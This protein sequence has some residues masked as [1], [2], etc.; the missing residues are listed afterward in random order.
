MSE[1]SDK[2]M[3]VRGNVV[4]VETEEF[5]TVRVPKAKGYEML[6]KGEASEVETE[7]SETEEKEK[8][9][10]FSRFKESKIAK[11]IVTG[12]AVVGGIIAAFAIGKNSGNNSDE[13]QF[14]DV[15]PENN[16]DDYTYSQIDGE[17]EKEEV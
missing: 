11:G 4:G 17:T 8:K 5:I 12:G 15:P 3:E 6:A 7:A 9:G 10:I 16:T 2:M 14:E 13:I 1:I